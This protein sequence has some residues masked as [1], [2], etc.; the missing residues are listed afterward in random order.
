MFYY[1]VGHNVTAS[2]SVELEHTSNLSILLH[3]AQPEHVYLVTVRAVN[4]VGGGM[5]AS[6]T[7]TVTETGLT[8][9]LSLAT[10]A[11]PCT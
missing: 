4:A 1:I 6:R 8:L 2:G 7:C 11:C 3:G 10:T 5:S 9:I